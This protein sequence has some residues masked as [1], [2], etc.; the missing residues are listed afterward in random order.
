[1]VDE[2][3]DLGT[4]VTLS[5]NAAAA[6]CG[7]LDLYVAS[8][9]PSTTTSLGSNAA[10]ALGQGGALRALTKQPS[11]SHR[12][13]EQSLEKIGFGSRA[14]WIPAQNGLSCLTGGG[15]FAQRDTCFEK[16]SGRTTVPGL[17]FT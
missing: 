4:L 11:R 3:I 16:A 10:V 13:R 2:S 9:S 12:W 7:V 6:T 1:M 14:I 5:K 15:A 17:A 8:L